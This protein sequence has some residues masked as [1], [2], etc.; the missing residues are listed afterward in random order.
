MNWQR[1]H[2]HGDTVISTKTF[3]VYRLAGLPE[4]LILAGYSRLACAVLQRRYP[5]TYISHSPT[6]TPRRD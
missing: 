5:G 4:S 6:L 3:I 2:D 1:G